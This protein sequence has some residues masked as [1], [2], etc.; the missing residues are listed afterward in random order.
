MH[1]VYV[2]INGPVGY[3]YK[4]NNNYF[5]LHENNKLTR[6]VYINEKNKNKLN[7]NNYIDM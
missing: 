4:I 5:F 6:K 7:K 2:V 3:S 1:V